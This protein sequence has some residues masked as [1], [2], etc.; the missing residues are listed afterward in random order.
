MTQEQKELLFK[1]ACKEVEIVAKF[2]QD[3]IRFCQE[4]LFKKKI[5][6]QFFIKENRYRMHGVPLTNSYLIGYLNTHLG[7]ENINVTYD[8]NSPISCNYIFPY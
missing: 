6:G 4:S 5:V 3:E 7:Y 1:L 8:S 2:L